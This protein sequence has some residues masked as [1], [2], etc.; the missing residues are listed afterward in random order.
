MSKLIE[1]VNA[2]CVEAMDKALKDGDAGVPFPEIKAELLN[3][4]SEQQKRLVTEFNRVILENT[5]QTKSIEEIAEE[6]EIKKQ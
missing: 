3:A 2:K 6:L 1:D 4:I 5:V